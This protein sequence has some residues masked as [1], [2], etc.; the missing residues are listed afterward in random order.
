VFKM[1]SVTLGTRVGEHTCSASVTK[2][3]KHPSASVCIGRM[4]DDAIT[5]PNG[6]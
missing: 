1:M 4:R 6:M 3:R 2:D 5:A